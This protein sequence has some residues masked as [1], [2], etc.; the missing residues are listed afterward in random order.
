MRRLFTKPQRFKIQTKLVVYYI[1]F[2]LITLGAVV[3]ISYTQAVNSLQATIDDKLSVIAGLKIDNLNHWIDEV[4][5][6]ADFQDI[7]IIDMNGKIA[8]SMIPAII[9]ASQTDQPFFMQGTSKTFT[10]P[11][12]ESS[13]LGGITLTVS[14]PLFDDSQ[15]RVGV[16]ALHFN[17]KRVD[18]I[19][20]ENPNMNDAVQSY[21]ITSDH[22]IITNDPVLLANSQSPES[23]ANLPA[24]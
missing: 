4:Q 17:L 11:F 10:Q 23:F 13:L 3:A 15:K 20:R 24:L 19:I 16:L 2:A 9:G 14:T 21:L 18:E 22:H 6:T 8:I 7:Q 5:R 12:Y 1:T